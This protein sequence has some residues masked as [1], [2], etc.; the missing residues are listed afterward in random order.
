M[1]SSAITRAAAAVSLLGVCALAGSVQSAKAQEAPAT[2][3]FVFSGIHIY[4]T[5][6]AHLDT[7]YASLTM[8]LGGVSQGKK[9]KKIGDL[10][11]GDHGIS[12]GA[13]GGPA[14]SSI[15]LSD[16][17]QK[18]DLAY[19]VLNSGHSD[20][21]Q[22][23]VD[24]AAGAALLLVP[25]VGPI[26]KATL[27]T[28]VGGLTGIIFA[29]CDG[30]VATGHFSW[31]EAQ[32]RGMFPPGRTRIDIVQKTYGTDSP[33][34]CGSNSDYDSHFIILKDVSPPVS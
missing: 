7:D 3:S 25:G 31:T 12:N 5:R 22:T 24:T 13:D 9:T 6:S 30:I 33:S 11:N 1:T 34:G 14:F 2:Y 20:T 29:N 10:N 21:A 15:V 23:A 4:N 32:L 19:S 16:P 18:I 8:N 17:N 27:G 26:A 28:L